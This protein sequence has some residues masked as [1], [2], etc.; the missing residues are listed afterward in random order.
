MLSSVFATQA[1]ALGGNLEIE[2]ADFKV[3]T[4]GRDGVRAKRGIRCVTTGKDG[5]S[6]SGY[7]VTLKTAAGASKSRR[8]H[9]RFACRKLYSTRYCRTTEPQRLNSKYA[10]KKRALNKRALKRNSR[11]AGDRS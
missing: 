10:L 5:A 1:S 9:A 8:L 3:G 4:P 2:R 11:N 7:Q 6:S